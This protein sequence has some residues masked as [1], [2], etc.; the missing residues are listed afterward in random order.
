M[1]DFCRLA[2]INFEEILLK[3]TFNSK[4]N[5]VFSASSGKI[6]SGT[7][8]ERGQDNSISHMDNID[9]C[10]YEL[11][12]SKKIIES[13]GY[14]LRI[15]R[16][17]LLKSFYKFSYQEKENIKIL[18]DI[19]KKIEKEFLEE[20]NRFFIGSSLS[21][22]YFKFLIKLV[23]YSI[24]VFLIA[25]IILF[26]IKKRLWSASNLIASIF[27]KKGKYRLHLLGRIVP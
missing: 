10:L 3:D 11:I 21:L 13:L 15:R 27:E 18:S 23:I 2:E 19:L 26:A 12:I 16:L 1:T 20:L 24:F 14:K 5:S 25:K 7:S 22:F 17:T 6:L 4:E 9:I 8:R